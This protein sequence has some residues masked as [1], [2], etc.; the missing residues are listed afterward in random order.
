MHSVY[1]YSISVLTDLRYSE[2]EAARIVRVLEEGNFA[3]AQKIS[4]QEIAENEQWLKDVASGIDVP[5]LWTPDAGEASRTVLLLAQ[6]PLRDEDYWD[7]IYCGDAGLEMEHSQA[8]IV[9]TPYALHLKTE[10]MKARMSNGKK[11]TWNIGIYRRLIEAIVEKGY[12]VYCTDIF[13]YYFQGHNLDINDFDRNILHAE[14]GRLNKR[15]LSHIVCM[16]NPAKRSMAELKTNNSIPIINTLHPR[17]R[18]WR[19]YGNQRWTDKA[20]I[21]YIVNQITTTA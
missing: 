12:N 4:Y 9:G 18:N 17:A 16:G 20:K 13:K 15:G 1:T 2:E 7:K 14:I 11:K 19:Q 3:Y 5:V 8:V 10:T 21:S 6:D